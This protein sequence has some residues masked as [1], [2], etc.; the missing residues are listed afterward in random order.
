MRDCGEPPLGVPMCRRSRR[1][2]YSPCQDPSVI[3]NKALRYLGRGSKS[4]SQGQGQNPIADERRIQEKSILVECRNLSK[5]L[6][7]YH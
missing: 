3:G 2:K 1:G 5:I 6:N 7:R 4:C